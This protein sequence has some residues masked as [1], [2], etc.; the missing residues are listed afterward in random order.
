V[1]SLE[2]LGLSNGQSGFDLALKQGLDHFLTSVEG[3]AEK[4]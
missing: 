4:A 2:E 3:G 1:T